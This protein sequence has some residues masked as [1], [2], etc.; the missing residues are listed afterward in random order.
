MTP[1]T[2]LLALTTTTAAAAA[3]AA[4]AATAAA[5]VVTHLTPAATTNL[6]HEAIDLHPHLIIIEKSTSTTTMELNGSRLT[7]R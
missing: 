2:D 7:L 1:H 5:A 3:A 6:N 4:A